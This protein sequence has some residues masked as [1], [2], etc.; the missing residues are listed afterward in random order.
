MSDRI[1]T[2]ITDS[3]GKKHPA[4]VRGCVPQKDLVVIYRDFESTKLLTETF[5]WVDGKWA[6][7]SGFSS[8]YDGGA[9]TTT[10]EITVRLSKK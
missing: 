4:E 10:P 3:K 9:V 5:T 1:I 8:D 2:Y 7:K 6:S